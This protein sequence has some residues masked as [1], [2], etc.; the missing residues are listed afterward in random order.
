MCDKFLFFGKLHW[1]IEC[2]VCNYYF[3]E[4][5]SVI[6]EISNEGEKSWERSQSI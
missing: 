5:L 4:K 2:N 1:C 3:G 6:E